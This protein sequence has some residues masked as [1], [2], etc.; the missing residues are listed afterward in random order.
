MKLKTKAI[1]FNPDSNMFTGVID[2]PDCPPNEYIGQMSIVTF[3]DDNKH[4]KEA[5]QKTNDILENDKGYLLLQKMCQRKT[6]D[7]SDIQ[8]QKAHQAKTDIWTILFHKFLIE[9]LEQDE[10]KVVKAPQYTDDIT[11][12]HIVIE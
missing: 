1:G 4:I 7:E 10:Y 8:Y 2:Q 9:A 11:E 6:F 12:N 3:G 5:R